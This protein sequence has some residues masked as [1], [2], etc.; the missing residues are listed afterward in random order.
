MK[1]NDDHV[2]TEVQAGRDFIREFVGT[3]ETNTLSP[4]ICFF[5]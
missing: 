4:N 2:Y 5:D 3:E 1:C